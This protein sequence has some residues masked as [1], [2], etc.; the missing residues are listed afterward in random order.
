MLE[1]N[2][3]VTACILCRNEER[4][5][6]DALRSLM[7]WTDQILVID[8]ESEDDTVAIARRYTDLILTAP[9]AH[10]FDAV[11]NLAIEHARGDWIFYLDADERVPFR[12]GPT[13]RQ[14][15]QERGHEFE[16][17]VIPFR[18]YFCGRW[19]QHSGWWPG[20]TRPQLLKRGRFR[21]SAR[22][23]SGV[24]V[25][26]RTLRF[27]AD[28]PDLA[29]AHYSYDTLSH[30]IG[31]L[32]RYTTGEAESLYAD[33]QSH[34]WQA[35]LAHFVQD[36]QL[37]YDGGRAHQDGMHGFV[38]SF[39]SAFYRFYSRAKLW[40]L[41]QRGE[42]PAPEPTPHSLSEMIAFMARVAREGAA[43]WLVADTPGGSLPSST[44]ESHLCQCLARMNLDSDRE[45]EMLYAAGASHCWQAQLEQCVRNWQAAYERPGG[46]REGMPGFVRAFLAG[47]AAFLSHAKLWELRRRRGE[48]VCPE[49]VP[50]SLDEMLAFISQVAPETAA[51]SL[52]R[53]DSPS[54]PLPV[55]LLWRGPLFDASG[56]ADGGRNLLLGLI[57][58][59]EPV[60][61]ASESW[62][63]PVPLAPGERDALA[64]RL[65]PPDTPANICVRQTLL[66][67][68]E[69]SPAARF[70]IARAMFET[71]GL[72]PGA[73]ERLNR[74]D[75]V[76]VPSR[77]NRETFARAGVDPDRIAV[78][79]EAIDAAPFA[80]PDLDPWPLDGE[81]AYRFL[82]VFDWSLHKG[83]D[84]LL[85][86]FASEFGDDPFVGLV[87]KVWSSLG[88]RLAEIQ[89]Q[90]DRHLQ[91]RLGRRLEDFPNI[92]F[93]QETLSVSD[94]PRLY[95][96]VDAFVL[97][98]RGE[99]WCRPLMEAMAAGLP[100]IAT[101]W[102]GLT[103]FHNARVGYPL[104]Y[105]VAPV[106][107]A[108]AREIPPYAGHCW[109]E[110]DPADLRRLMRELVEDP[111]TA[112][113]R[114]FAAK[115]TI[116]HQFSRAAVAGLV[117]DEIARC[118][119]RVQ[120]S[121]PT[122]LR[123]PE[124]G[125]PFQSEAPATEEAAPASSPA[126][127]QPRRLIRDP[128]API[129]FRARLGR[130]LRVRWEGHQALLSSLALVNRQLCLALLAAG[131]VEL[132]LSETPNPWEEIAAAGDPRLEA[133]LSCRD[134]PLSGPPDVT[135]RHHFP[136]DWQRP[137]E[138]A[139]VVMQPWE[140]GH[141][142]RDWVE[143]ARN[144]DEVWTYSRFVRDVYVR[145]GVPAEKVRVVPLGFD[146]A[147][148]CPEGPR[149]A[150][151]TRCATRFLF[152]GGALD[153][154][155]ADL[156]LSAYVNA[157]TASD[158]VCLVVKDMGTRTFYRGQ[159]LAE[160]FRR[161]RR[162]PRAPEILY[163]DQ[164]LTDRQLASL[165][166]AC[167]CVVLPYRAEGFALS[168]LEGMG[169]GLPAIVTAGGPTED[170]LD[171]TM[172][173]RV[174]SRRRPSE[175]PN[176]GPFECVG[177]PWRLEPDPAALVSALRWVY[178]HPEEARRRGQRAR[179][180][181]ADAWT[182]DRSVELLRERLAERVA[183]PSRPPS[184]VTLWG[185]PDA[186]GDP[187]IADAGSP[188]RVTLPLSVVSDRPELSLCLIARDEERRI[189]EC[190]TSIAPFVDEMVV[191]DTGSVDRTRQ[192]ARACGAR[193]F[194]FPW[195]DCFATA[196]NAS[197]D[198]ARGRWIF[199]MDADDVIPEE[200]ARRLRELI[201]RA[202]DGGVA[203]QVQVRIPPGPGEFSESAVDHVK[204][205]PNRPDLRFEHRLHEQILPA[206]RRAGLEVCFSDLYVIHQNY[207]RSEEGQTKKRQRDFRLLDLDLRD[208]PD[209]P[210]VLFN[211]GMT[212]LFATHDYEVAAHY[213]RR[214]LASSDWRDSI[215]RKAYA[216]LA[217]ARTCLQEW[218][219]ALAANEEGRSHYPEDAEL[220]FQAGDLYQRV[221]RHEE[222]RQAL[223]RLVT[224]TDEAHFRSVDT[225]LRTFRGRHELALLYRRMGDGRHCAELLWKIADAFPDYVP[226]RIDLV[227]TLCLLGDREEAR[228]LL[229][230]LPPVDAVRNRLPY[231]QQLVDEGIAFRVRA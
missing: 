101:A 227:E 220:L 100:T 209:H 200:S 156:L 115:G 130:P 121:R 106:S 111:D 18:H 188:D 72:P 107:P 40:E 50:A 19:M 128:V 225:G 91:E 94:L 194:D 126:S 228:R 14:L 141:L 146:P 103:E 47:I 45:A 53:P 81:E 224:E 16:A 155:G 170:Y 167:T 84:I 145:S 6:E 129:D 76:W 15:L 138:G 165:Y 179:A 159:T 163:L 78:L 79:P 23:H 86:A 102:S 80:A 27:P 55:P 64:S 42:R 158:D 231:L 92:H 223:E 181:V 139:L 43:P 123:A 153:R 210:F 184:E 221:D 114:G 168:P 176:V 49:P 108:G 169:S 162:D 4:Q 131:D 122:S 150:L 110:P 174:P 60:A 46:E 198:Q 1:S 25:Q 182:W 154:K 134:H 226:A 93:W 2:P 136:P 56:F 41:R 75:R 119:E 24:Q 230:S 208:R 216:L 10:N 32:N 173:L 52:P 88:Y 22:L 38:L 125:R 205:F 20:Y 11:R 195:V 58:A 185:E 7:E 97:P 177:D 29:I 66:S 67:H 215:V 120:D 77:F 54:P 65:L 187:G 104:A 211:L 37:Y 117:R 57:E 59:G 191:V 8:N 69:P 96:A 193:V 21:Y 164:D 44:T 213:L 90:A 190:L 151:P 3:T 5:I 12:L 160:A 201:R 133:L 34:S 31:K 197:L 135:I 112:R 87:L 143:G 196:R 63:G 71:D 13:L 68:L 33:G 186:T 132:T 105:A 39:L 140:Y 171:D 218:E 172:A 98:T 36:W 144:A 206:L 83:W 73:V 28:D 207:D 30:Y 147:L 189:R 202:P 62:G 175:E 70:N 48:A 222:A 124:S 82:S 161:V 214:S 74:M 89:E 127:I 61:A 178:D 203:Y 9:R 149:F 199:W 118:R 99:G 152:V 116:A 180:Y 95:R 217:T 157:F 166:R 192:I 183:L 204:L 212:H 137:A 148:F 51:P 219:T 142:P 229:A 26:G 109:A 17:V 85:E 113:F 35:Q